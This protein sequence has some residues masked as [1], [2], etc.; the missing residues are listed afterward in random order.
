MPVMADAAVL[1]PVRMIKLTQQRSLRPTSE[2][3]QTR[4]GE[5]QVVV[6]LYESKHEHSKPGKDDCDKETVGNDFIT[7]PHDRTPLFDQN[8]IPMHRRAARQP[9][10]DQ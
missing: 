7:C 3:I 6:I 8:V 4:R 10:S 1:A 5:R 2:C 9:V